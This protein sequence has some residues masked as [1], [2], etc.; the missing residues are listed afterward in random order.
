MAL[1]RDKSFRVQDDYKSSQQE[2]S[3]SFHMCKISRHQRDVDILVSAGINQFGLS[4]SIFFG[5]GA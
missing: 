1:G 4:A 5:R 2:N 3:I